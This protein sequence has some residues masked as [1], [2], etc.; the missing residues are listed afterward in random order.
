MAATAASPARTEYESWEC[1][2]CCLGSEKAIGHA[3]PHKAFLGSSKNPRRDG[4]P[5]TNPAPKAASPKQ[6]PRLNPPGPTQVLGELP[7][8]PA[9]GC[10]QP[11]LP[12]TLLFD[13]DY[14]SHTFY[15]WKKAERWLSEA[16]GFVF[17]G[18]SFSVTVT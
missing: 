14:E 9:E 15:Q 1:T 16:D 8:C 18:T 13:E 10:G 11:C 6:S 4:S 12:Q 2:S 7:C 3:G 5:A 17:V